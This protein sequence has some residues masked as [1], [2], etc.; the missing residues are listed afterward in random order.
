M[1][2]QAIVDA[3]K[4]VLSASKAMIDVADTQPLEV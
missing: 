1:E 3:A 2:A 4:E